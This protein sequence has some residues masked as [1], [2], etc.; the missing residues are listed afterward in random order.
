MSN[1]LRSDT[2]AT[3]IVP[4]FHDDN[5]SLMPKLRLIGLTLLALSATAVSHAEE[6]R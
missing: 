3:T 5:D 6:T 1:A 2:D 4:P